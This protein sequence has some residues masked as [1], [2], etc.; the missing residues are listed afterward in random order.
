MLLTPDSSREPANFYLFLDN[1]LDAEVLHAQF[2][3]AL[4]QKKYADHMRQLAN[5]LADAV[6]MHEDLITDHIAIIVTSDHGYTELPD[7]IDVIPVPSRS[8]N[9]S[10]VAADESFSVPLQGVHNSFPPLHF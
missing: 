10:F 8:K 3:P 1:Q 5:S 9:R 6:S 7:R 4:R 2:P